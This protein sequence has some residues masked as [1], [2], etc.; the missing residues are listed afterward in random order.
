MIFSIANNYYSYYQYSDDKDRNY[1]EF[2]ELLGMVWDERD[3]NVLWFYRTSQ[4][5]DDDAVSMTLLLLLDDAGEEV[6]RRLYA[7]G[8]NGWKMTDYPRDPPLFPLPTS[9]MA[10]DLSDEELVCWHMS[11]LDSEFEC[12]DLRPAWLN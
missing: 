7:P 2:P 12:P 11:L 4:P 5:T 8:S 9:A 3:D 10:L 6:A 1:M